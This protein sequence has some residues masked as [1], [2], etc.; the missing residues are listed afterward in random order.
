MK[1]GNLGLVGVFTKHSVVNAVVDLLQTAF[2]NLSKEN[3]H[4]HVLMLRMTLIDLNA[5]K[6]QFDFVK[7]GHVWCQLHVEVVQLFVIV[8]HHSAG[9]VCL[10]ELARFEAMG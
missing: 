1:L 10:Q 7:V 2:T 4:S 3:L 8:R 9:W 5:A 6:V